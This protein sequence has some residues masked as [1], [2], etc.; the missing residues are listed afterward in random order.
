[1]NLSLI[2]SNEQKIDTQSK[3]ILKLLKH[4]GLK[5]FFFYG[6]RLSKLRKLERLQF[7]I[8]DEYLRE[9]DNEYKS[10]I[11][12]NYELLKTTKIIFLVYE[13]E[14]NFF[15]GATRNIEGDIHH[16]G[17]S[18]C[19]ARRTK[20]GFFDL[21]KNYYI[22]EMQGKIDHWGYLYL[23]TS[24]TKFAFFKK[25]P[26]KYVG[27]ISS[28]GLIQLRNIEN[29]MNYMLPHSAIG[30]LIANHFGDEETKNQEFKTNIIRLK[31]RLEKFRTD[32][33]KKTN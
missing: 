13:E 11:Q 30:K 3:R 18:Y 20:Y 33:N 24:R 16:N 4:G 22:E 12:R 5:K 26:K 19:K 29:E 23:E 32:L 28:N 7:S 1:M 10:I 9:T 25:V 31:E 2:I 17:Y 27:E 8:I 21:T 15:G 14:I 6:I